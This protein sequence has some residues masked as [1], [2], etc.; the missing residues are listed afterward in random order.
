MLWE[1]VTGTPALVWQIRDEFPEEV[2]LELN[3]DEVGTNQA[4]RRVGKS[5][6]QWLQGQKEHGA[7][8]KVKEEWGDWLRGGK[9]HTSYTRVI[10]SWVPWLLGS[11]IRRRGGR[12]KTKWI[13]KL[14]HGAIT[15]RP[16]PTPQGA[17]NWDGPSVLGQG[18]SLHVSMLNSH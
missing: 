10:V 1:F 18:N 6:Q 12:S 3:S 13:E 7:M 4:K 14:C 9:W 16:Q 17:L 11:L 2:S 8:Q 5:E 15:G